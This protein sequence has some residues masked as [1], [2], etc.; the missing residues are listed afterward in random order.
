VSITELKPREGKRVPRYFD[1]TETVDVTID[2]GDLHDAGWHHENECPA[3]PGPL[4]DE[5]SL[6]QA[7]WTALVALHHEAHGPGSI[8]LCLKGACAS[9]SLDQLRGAA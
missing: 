3:E 2:A 5:D 1:T 9:L 7:Y 6:A 4:V 8:A